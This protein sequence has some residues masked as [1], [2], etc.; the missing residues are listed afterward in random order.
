MEYLYYIDICIGR[1]VA[2]GE[3]R[4]IC[5]VFLN[6]CDCVGCSLVKVAS[7]GYV[8]ERNCLGE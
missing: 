3:G 7:C 1:D 2:I 6:N 5:C 8:G 4:D